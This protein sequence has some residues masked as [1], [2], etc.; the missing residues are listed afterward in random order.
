MPRGSR[1]PAIQAFRALAGVA[2]GAN[3]VQRAPESIAASGCFTRPLAITIAAPAA[4]AM[5]PASIFVFMPPRERSEPA[6]PAIAS[7]AEV[8][9]GTKSM[10]EAFGSA[11]GGAV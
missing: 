4:V 6:E 5:R 9:A 11:A 2:C 3:Q 1:C 7:I 8:I 10:K